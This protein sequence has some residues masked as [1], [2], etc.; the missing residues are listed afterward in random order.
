MKIS[1]RAMRPSEAGTVSALMS[2]VIS[3]A[4]LYNQRARKHEAAKYTAQH[5]ADLA[6][7]WKHGVLVATIDNHIAGFVVAQ[8][9]DETV[10]V[11][12]LGVSEQAR[13]HGLASLLLG[14][15][16]ARAKRDGFPK[17]W[18]DSRTENTPI[19]LLL[20]KRNYSSLCTIRAHWYGQD[21]MLWE[22]FL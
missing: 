5:L 10:W 8:D 16:E 19:R 11:S 4:T 21:F 3:K 9:Q 20:T 12:W 17:I 13:G 6:K 7:A 18:C 1:I 14:K 2:E 22:K 15:L